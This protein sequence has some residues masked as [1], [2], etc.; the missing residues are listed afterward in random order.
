[1][2]LVVKEACTLTTNIFMIKNVAVFLAFRSKSDDG[3]KASRKKVRLMILIYLF[4]I[5]CIVIYDSIIWIR[6][7]VKDIT[8]SDAALIT[9]LGVNIVRF[10]L[11][12]ALSGVSIASAIHLNTIIKLIELSNVPKQQENQTI[13]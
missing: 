5:V 11:N 2:L 8:P 13:E 6:F 3:K 10:L 7:S 1:M 12:A 9:Y 4:T